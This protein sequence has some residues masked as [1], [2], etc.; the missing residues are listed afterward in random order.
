MLFLLALPIFLAVATA[1]R[2]LALYAPSNLLI[3][4]VRMSPPRCRTVVALVVLTA[5]LL[6]AMRA[7]D[8]AINV[9]APGWL[10]LIAL[11]LAWDAIK[12]A[13]LAT[14]T[15]FRCLTRGRKRSTT[16]DAVL[17]SGQS[18]RTDG[19]RRSASVSTTR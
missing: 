8:L 16:L 7:V 6:L 4:H 14:A 18:R 13:A 11:V 1:H 15:S 3:R 10:S 19:Y 9:G 12:V 2:Y 5:V 17:E